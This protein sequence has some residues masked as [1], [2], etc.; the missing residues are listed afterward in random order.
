MN[1]LSHDAA[2]LLRQARAQQPQLDRQ[3]REAV[4]QA[5]A[6]AVGASVAGAA[7][8]LVGASKPM[9][10]GWFATTAGKLVVGLGAAIV[11]ST[12]TVGVVSA[13]RAL[14]RATSAAAGPARAPSGTP[15]ASAVRPLGERVTHPAVVE[16]RPALSAPS[17]TA[18]V[19][20]ARGAGP[21]LAPTDTRTPTDGV[22][23]TPALGRA[24][25]AGAAS[26][27]E[28]DTRGARAPGSSAGEPGVA[29]ELPRAASTNDGRAQAPWRADASPLVPDTN[30]AG[31]GAGAA[32]GAG[33]ADELVGDLRDELVVL[34]A[35]LSHHEA[36]RDE[37]ALGRLDEYQR[38]FGG[39]V[40]RTEAE[41]LR[42]L[43]L[44][45]LGRKAEATA[46]L[47]ALRRSASSSPAAQR[48]STSCAAE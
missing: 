18:V 28:R 10:S 8:E 32:G 36:A 44:C 15:G 45:R 25:A 6:M 2:A 47:Q 37:A 5:V 40:L 20:D 39:G 24:T 11:G 21:G 17:G 26:P 7:A 46:L 4:K 48:L 33:G 1:E 35:A 27:S 14:A 9:V 16:K 13:K 42:V 34:R 22:A 19:S 31:P 3:R 38:R 41:T 23:R 30:S 43:V 29:P 12:A